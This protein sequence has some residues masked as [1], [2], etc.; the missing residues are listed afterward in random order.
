MGQ[1]QLQEAGDKKQPDQ[2]V[3]ESVQ[4]ELLRISALINELTLSRRRPL[5]D[6]KKELQSLVARITEVDPS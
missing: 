3:Y 6:E 4:E 2:P 5:G 1:H